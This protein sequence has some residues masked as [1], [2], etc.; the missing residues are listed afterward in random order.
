MTFFR[1]EHDVALK[2]RWYL[3]RPLAPDGSRNYDFWPL[4]SGNRIG[5]PEHPLRIDV[6]EKGQPLAFTLAGFDVPVVEV[7]LAEAMQRV[8]SEAI[9]R[10]PASISSNSQG[11]EVLVVAR[12]VECV[13]EA[14]S[15]FTKWGTGDGR[16][17]K[18]GQYRMFV[19]LAIDYSKV[20]KG[21]DIFRIAGWHV[22]LVVSGRMRAAME[23]K[24]CRG[25]VFQ[26]L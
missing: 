1:I 5:E 22:A 21:S 4:M 16:P 9:Q 25:V 14:R 3:T 6:R 17:D 19:H 15:K 23:A 10:V 7:G 26:E 20:P 18:V 13:D 11:Y 24:G 8:D 2:D 12:E